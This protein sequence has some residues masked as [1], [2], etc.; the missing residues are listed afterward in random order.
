VSSPGLEDLEAIAWG[1][2]SQPP[3]VS[4]TLDFLNRFCKD[5]PKET[6]DSARGPALAYDVFQYLP[7]TR[8]LEILERHF[9]AALHVLPARQG[10]KY[11]EAF[12]TVMNNLAARKITG[13]PW[14][15]KAWETF[16]AA[17]S[18]EHIH[19]SFYTTESYGWHFGK[20]TIHPM[21]VSFPYLGMGR[22]EETVPIVKATLSE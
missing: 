5:T 11:L 16:I 4:A 14:G 10:I 21:R 8:S 3:H 22:S 18:Q 20:F 7:P 2:T 19:N 9:A 12:I 17:I 15:K 1:C 13:S 6:V